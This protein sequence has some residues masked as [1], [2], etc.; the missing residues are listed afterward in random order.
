[1]P[2]LRV[3]ILV[4]LLVA[5]LAAA[6]AWLAI[7]AQSD[8][9]PLN[10][11]E[12]QPRDEEQSQQQQS[13]AQPDPGPD[14]E[15]AEQQSAEQEQSEELQEEE[16]SDQTEAVEPSSSAVDVLIKALDIPRPLVEPEPALEPETTV[17]IEYETYVVEPGDT[18]ADIAEALAIDLH[19]LIETNQLT[20][21]DLLYVGRELAIPVEV[22]VVEPIEE[23]LPLHEPE[24]IAPST[25]ENGIVYGTI[26]DRARGVINSAVIVRSDSDQSV[27][28]VEACVD[29]L[30]RTYILGLSLP[31]GPAPIYWRIDEG[32][33]S[34]DRWTAEADRVESISWSP[35][36][37]LVDEE[38]GPRSLWIR[39]G[40]V[41]LT[42]D[43]ENW[44]PDPIRNNFSFCDK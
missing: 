39:I 21:P 8:P 27:Q 43:I 30:R 20:S 25:S 35:I 17:A 15:Q 5:T 18:L 13:Q 22:M 24:E 32:P 7:D 11:A 38:A 31:E 33:V 44:I 3:R 16:A 2:R 1:M 29:G 9:E 23:S 10:T 42:F 6:S 4:L 40:G 37:Q 19:E 41:D 14:E 26:H 36:L 12:H 28:L 34:L